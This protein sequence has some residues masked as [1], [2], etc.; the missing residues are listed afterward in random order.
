MADKRGDVELSVLAKSESKPAANH[1]D[2]V[3]VMR[4]RGG[5]DV[6]E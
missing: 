1:C 5:D 3:D 6:G 4:G 2:V